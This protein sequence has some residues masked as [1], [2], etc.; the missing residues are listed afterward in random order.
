[1]RLPH[2]QRYIGRRQ[3]CEPQCGHGSPLSGRQRGHRF[4]HCQ[5][6]AYSDSINDLPLLEAVQQ[7]V[8]VNADARLAALAEQRGWR[9]LTLSHKEPVVSRI[10]KH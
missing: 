7:A 8:A 9:R 5:T 6:I 4:E 1:V 10:M 3:L 2:C